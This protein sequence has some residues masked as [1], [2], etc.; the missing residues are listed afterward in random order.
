MPRR[1]EPGGFWPPLCS[2]LICI[3]LVALGQLADEGVNDRTGVEFDYRMYLMSSGYYDGL[4]EDAVVN[5]DNILEQEETGVL[6]ELNGQSK[7]TWRSRYILSADLSYQYSPGPGKQKETE[8][9]LSAME[10]YLDLLVK[11]LFYFKAGRKR[12]SWSVGNVFYPVDIINSPKNPLDPSKSRDGTYLAMVEVPFGTSAASIV[13]FPRVEFDP[14]DK[15]GIPKR[16]D[17]DEGGFGGRLYSLIRDTDLSLIYY[18]LDRIPT[19]ERNFFGFTA[20]RFFGYLG[21]YIELLGHTGSDTDLVR[22]D[23]S[24][25]YYFPDPKERIERARADN[26]EYLDFSAGASYTFSDDTKVGVE[27]M[28]NGEGYDENTFE[29]FRDFLTHDSQVYLESNDEGIKN[30]L[31]RGSR[32]LQNRIRRN[33]LA[34]TL[35]RPNTFDDFFPRL[36]TIMCLDDGS[37]VVNG[38]VDYLI[39]YDTTVKLMFSTPVGNEKTEYGLKPS[40][41][42]ITL[43]A[44]Y[45]W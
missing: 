27:Y 25:N 10:L 13:Y 18:R 33:Y 29:E 42:R 32:M 34:V 14:D 17:L 26:T 8:T 40:D 45:Y 23:Q 31:L 3:P 20:N 41:Y 22:K 38:L 19:L 28:R 5:P 1:L 7:T 44:K 43:E 11:D 12:E 21:A 9:H 24:G 39:R 36:M 4:K 35:D 2:V 15:D 30:K 6:V 16:M 37:F